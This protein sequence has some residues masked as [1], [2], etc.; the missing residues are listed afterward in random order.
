MAFFFLIFKNKLILNANST[1]LIAETYGLYGEMFNFIEFPL[2]I[3]TTKFY[4]AVFGLICML[5]KRSKKMKE[6]ALT[7][8]NN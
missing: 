6:I 8:N 2:G 5:P 4:R 1:C 3:S 7:N